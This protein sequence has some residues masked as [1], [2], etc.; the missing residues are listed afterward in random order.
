MS[1]ARPMRSISSAV[2]L[3]ARARV[4]GARMRRTTS[5]ISC[6]IR[7]SLPVFASAC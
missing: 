5:D 3:T 4:T 2:K 1:A 6:R 7:S